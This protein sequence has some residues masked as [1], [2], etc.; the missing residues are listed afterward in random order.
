M[1]D[2]DDAPLWRGLRPDTQWREFGQCICD[3]GFSIFRTKLRDVVNRWPEHNHLRAIRCPD[4]HRGVYVFRD[5]S[6]DGEFLYVGK[7]EH[8]VE[9][10][11]IKVRI[12]QHLTPKDT[13]GD[14]RQN[15]CAGKCQEEGCGCKS[16]CGGIN[17]NCVGPEFRRFELRMVDC[18]VWTITKPPGDS[19][20]MTNLEDRLIELTNPTYQTS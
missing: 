3:K 14:L 9:S 17:A 13:A 7:S 19:G 4:R 10:R 12:G 2:L 5:P 11:D 16:T 6:G 8:G 1:C 20:P 15:W 18:E